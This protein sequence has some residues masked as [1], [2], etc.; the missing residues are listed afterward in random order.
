MDLKL[1][2]KFKQSKTIFNNISRD[3]PTVFQNIYRPAPNQPEALFQFAL[4]V[5]AK[6][7]SEH[8]YNA[9]ENA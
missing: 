7:L 9:P 5:P 2:L 8:H 1:Q 6:A 4:S 3:L